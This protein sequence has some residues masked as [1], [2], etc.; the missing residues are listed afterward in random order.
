[1]VS[2]IW[3]VYTTL[4]VYGWWLPQATID[5]GDKFNGSGLSVSGVKMARKLDGCNYA[6]YFETQIHAAQTRQCFGS[7]LISLVVGT[8][9]WQPSRPSNRLQQYDVLPAPPIQGL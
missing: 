1:V 6:L 4:H 7:T 3:V 9:G 2:L 8:G 5:A